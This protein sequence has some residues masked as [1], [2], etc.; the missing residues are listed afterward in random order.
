MTRIP[1]HTVD[2]APA[3]SRPLLEHFARQSRGARRLL[4]LHAEMAHSPVALAAYYGMRRA[5]DE[6]ATLD[7]RTRTAIMSAEPN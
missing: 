2:D 7:P 6:H 5:F 4:N 1:A 3:A